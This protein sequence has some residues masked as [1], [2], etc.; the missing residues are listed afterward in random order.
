MMTDYY[1]IVS[2]VNQNCSVCTLFECK[3]FLVLHAPEKKKSD[4]LSL[5]RRQCF[6]ISFVFLCFVFQST[7]NSSIL[8][9]SLSLFFFFLVFC[10]FRVAPVAYGGSQAKMLLPVYTRATGMP[11][12][13]C[14]CDLHYS[15]WQYRSVTY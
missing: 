2:R 10:L 5:K 3:Y 9:L 13:S 7:S 4:E 8:F 12:P 14:V 6:N 15:S 11:D 1:E